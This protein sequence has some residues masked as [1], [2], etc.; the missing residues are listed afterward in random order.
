MYMVFLL[1]AE[2]GVLVD[3][4]IAPEGKRQGLR[5]FDQGIVHFGDGFRREAGRGT[6]KRQGSVQA[7]LEAEYGNRHRGGGR[8]AFSARDRDQPPADRFM[9]QAL[10]A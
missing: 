7:L 9:A 1:F 6:G 3:M 8:I 5:C 10:G 2:H 4:G